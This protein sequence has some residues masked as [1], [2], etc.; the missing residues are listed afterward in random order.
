MAFSAVAAIAG[1]F[2]A[3]LG[4]TAWLGTELWFAGAASS[5]VAAD[6]L[7]GQIISGAAS[8]ATRAAYSSLSGGGDDGGGSGG[9][10]PQASSI[11]AQRAQGVLINVAS[12]IEPV[13]VVMGFRRVGGIRA[14]IDVS[15]A[16]STA[17]ASETYT[18]AGGTPSFTVANA[19][20][21]VSD[22]GVTFL[23]TQYVDDLG[24]SN[25]TVGAPLVKVSGS[26]A[27]GQYAV[28][29]GVYTFAAA[30][31]GLQ[32]EVAYSYTASTLQ[33]EYLNL[34]IVLSEGQIGGIDRIYLDDR[35]STD[36]AYA[37]L[38]ALERYLGTASQK[39]SKLLMA[40]VPTKWT[41]AHVGN[42]LA[43]IAARVKQAQSAFPSGAPTFT[44]DLR[45]AIHYDP[46]DGQTRFSNNAALAVRTYLISTDFGRGID[47][48]LLDDD[49]FIDAADH[50]DERVDVNRV[51]WTITADA[52]SDTVR[53]DKE[54][55]L[56]SNG[57]G[58]RISAA[59]SLPGGLI[60]NQTYYAIR[61]HGRALRLATS[62]ANA[63]A[64]VA[65][66][67]TS[68]GA[69]TLTLTHWDEA[70][71]TSNGVVNT[72]DPLIDNIRLL[73]TACRGWL[74]HSGGK[75]RLVIDREVD[76]SAA[77]E[78]NEDNITGGWEIRKPGRRERYNKVVARWFNPA[79]NWQPDL[80]P[81]ADAGYL[82]A[83]GGQVSEVAFDLPFSSSHYTVHRIAQQEL[84]QSRFGTS[85]RFTALQEGLECRV[86]EVVKI[87]HSMP[88][89][90]GAL[91]RIMRMEIKNDD[92]VVIEA[93][94]YNPAVYGIG[95][96]AD[97]DD[98][99]E[100]SLGNPLDVAAPGSVTLESGE[101]NLLMQADG[102]V[103]SRIRVSWPAS[104]DA[105]VV[106]AEIQIKRAA[107]TAWVVAIRAGA[108]E[109]G[110]WLAPVEDGEIY[111]VRI[112][113]ENRIGVFSAWTSA[114]HT[115][116]GKE[117]LP[118]D[119]T[120][121]S[122][123]GTVLSWTAV[124]DADL[125][126]YVFRFNYGANTDWGAAAPLHAGLITESPYPLASRPAGVITLMGKARDRSG[127]ESEHAAVVVTDLG[128]AAIANVV[129]TIDFAAA[130]FP[131]TYDYGTSVVAGELV[132]ANLDS[133][134]GDP[135]Q[136][137]QAFYGPD[138]EP[139]YA[140][141]AY[142]SLWYAA[143][144][145]VITSVLAGSM[146]TLQLTTEGSYLTVMYRRVGSLP[147]YGADVDTFYGPDADSFYDTDSSEWLPWPGQLV[148]EA[149]GYQF[150]VQI[151]GSAAQGKVTA[152]ALVIDAPDLTETIDNL[153][154]SA[155]G[156]AIPYTKPFTSIK[157][158]QATL[159]ANG[160]GAITVEID[161][162]VPLA[163]T[164]KAYDA[165]HAAVSG[166][167]ADITLKGY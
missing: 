81:E 115:V 106:R 109:T 142:A 98:S 119:I 118:G 120:D 150:L 26:P 88:G 123:A 41:A 30:D 62:P 64:M 155:S 33:N 9:A 90:S 147:L 149:G 89:W 141:T 151:A 162:T 45:G 157:N 135:G 25:T 124:A 97:A 57:D 46:R 47:P 128:D 100:S 165:S 51:S 93:R 107:D 164:I 102:T 101:A 49:A 29:N 14:F 4:I 110:T 38:L 116:T 131:G 61:V 66:N 40:E 154:I 6:V 138:T 72:D 114:Q 111:D 144:D 53:L 95:P 139:F 10:G 148:A 54:S 11:S 43:Y 28:A 34:A 137:T 156:T 163:P 68:A 136:G 2:A 1:S 16:R 70:R 8:L 91:F 58:V 37:G 22:A 152:M 3:E 158:V 127:L 105:L 48:S 161:K 74:V 117:A 56:I 32:V 159:Q 19:A 108:E 121:L 78:F 69:G 23:G 77:F 15:S 160:S 7:A 20:A 60:A 125:A 75:Y 104:S 27:A 44:A 12:N 103:V 129:E 18:I 85:A 84:R 42:R 73:L 87:T 82:A 126:G 21:F 130:D 166:A 153:A 86:G 145:V 134:Y 65:V 112:R 63:L 92:E 96:I 67:I 99:L 31:A 71:Y 39:A 143:E 113:F 13:P 76:T 35:I 17:S 50:C 55:W 36:P 5:L 146:M 52:A 132:A 133:F 59:G 83:D 79:K 140:T 94:E 24:N 122:I 167:T 80:A